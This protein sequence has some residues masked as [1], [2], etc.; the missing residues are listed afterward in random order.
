MRKR[1][2]FTLLEVLLAIVILVVVA[3]TTAR[4]AG[5]FS[6]AM[7]KSSVRV[8]ASAVAAD[9]LELIRADPRYPRLVSLYG[10]GAGAD[11]TGFP[12]Y[13]QMRRTTTIVRDQSG[14]PPRDRTTLTV[15]V[16]DPSLKDTVAVTTVIA[17][18]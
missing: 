2:G 10:T 7:S 8:T 18:P 6:R 14:T 5:D 15:R 1:N 13:A 11:T 17:S 16:S 12:G 3:T 4:F 9:R